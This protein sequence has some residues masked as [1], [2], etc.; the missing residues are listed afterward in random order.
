M[1]ILLTRRC[2]IKF[3]CSMLFFHGCWCSSWTC[4]QVAVNL[5]CNQLLDAVLG[6]KYEQRPMNNS[7]VCSLHLVRPETTLI[8]IT[9]LCSLHLFDTLKHNWT[10]SYRTINNCKFPS[11]NFDFISFHTKHSSPTD[12]NK[13]VSFF[14]SYPNQ[15]KT[16]N[17]SKMCQ[18]SSTAMICEQCRRLVNYTSITSFCRATENDRRECLKKLQDKSKYVSFLEC[19]KC[20]PSRE[21]IAK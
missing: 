15:T 20:N 5:V 3:P 18:L 13:S 7:M 16:E 10:H 19:K 8:F 9:S 21:G 4:I 2:D 14:L 12:T 1:S 6:A 17:S 11:S